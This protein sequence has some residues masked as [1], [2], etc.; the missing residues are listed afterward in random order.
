[1]STAGIFVPHSKINKKLLNSLPKSWDMNASVIKKTR[2]LN[3]LTLAETM[4]IIKACDLDD[5][6]REINHVSSYSTANLRISSNNVFTS[7]T[8]PQ[9]QAFTIPQTHVVPS[10]MPYPKTHVVPHSASSSKAP[11]YVSTPKEVEETLALAS[12]LVNCYNAFL[13]RELPPQISSADLDQIHPKD[14]EEMDIN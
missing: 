14:V 3:K 5:K 2:H 4:A 9:T 10:S 13:A 8:V 11:P 6:P 12:C 7:F 1:M